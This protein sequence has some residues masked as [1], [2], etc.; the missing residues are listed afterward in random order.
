MPFIYC[1]CA[2]TQ[3][4]RLIDDS[5]DVDRGCGDQ[6]D[7]ATGQ[8]MTMRGERTAATPKDRIEEVKLIDNEEYKINAAIVLIKV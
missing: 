8:S 4:R 1:S 5:R 7:E 6:R 2:S 3:A